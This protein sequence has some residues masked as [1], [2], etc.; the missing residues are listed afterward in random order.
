MISPIGALKCNLPIKEIM[1]YRPPDG[2]TDHQKDRPGHRELTLP[3]RIEFVF[4]I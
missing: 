1:T 4:L 2:P 3:I